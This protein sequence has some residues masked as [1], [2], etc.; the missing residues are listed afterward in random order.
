MGF[1]S[2]VIADARPARSVTNSSQRSNS[3]ADAGSAARFMETSGPLT[4]GA[5]AVQENRPH[6][7]NAVVDAGGPGARAGADPGRVESSAS[8]HDASP[9]RLPIDSVAKNGPIEPGPDR[10]GELYQPVGE[11]RPAIDALPAAPESND[12]ADRVVVSPLP[13]P[14][15]PEI[16]PVEQESTLPMDEAPRFQEEVSS[17]MEP[18]PHSTELFE[19]TSNRESEQSF[20]PISIDTDP[21]RAQDDRL[22]IPDKLTQADALNL[23]PIDNSSDDGQPGL[24]EEV[25]PAE[26][27]LASKPAAE[28]FPT[29]ET[30]LEP[31][32]AKEKQDS[33]VTVDR[34]SVGIPPEKPKGK[35]LSAKAPG[36]QLEAVRH[37]HDAASSA[38]VSVKAETSR[39]IISSDTASKPPQSGQLTPEPVSQ[40]QRADQDYKESRLVPNSTDAEQLSVAKT[41]QDNVINKVVPRAQPVARSPAR[42]QSNSVQASPLTAQA[43]AT[44]PPVRAQHRD[45]V[46]RNNI[47]HNTN[48][49]FTPPPR[50]PEVKIGQV[51]VFIEAPHRPASPGP[52]ASRPSPSLA[53]RHYLRRL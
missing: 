48:I 41:G 32:S 37:D 45:S 39:P 19:E 22:P 6:E 26:M 23:D 33:T 30:K 25:R 14:N 2:S 13:R 35:A 51:D 31:V 18:T 28:A 52:T 1:L 17:E 8:M 20:E 49:A 44:A 10:S 9:S 21:T 40:L 36:R 5:V 3:A 4:S 29:P 50:T 7:A 11:N 42:A 46:S 15:A 24:A 16:G 38:R 12:D 34:N 43:Q 27:K 53:S 47:G